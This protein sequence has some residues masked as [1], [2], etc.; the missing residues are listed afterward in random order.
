MYY[1]KWRRG[2]VQLPF[3][4]Q[5]GPNVQAG[6][7]NYPQGGHY[8]QGGNYPNQPQGNNPNQ[9]HPGYYNNTNNYPQL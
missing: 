6:P 3:L 8:P 2:E 1:F 7:G 9:G 5:S 4:N